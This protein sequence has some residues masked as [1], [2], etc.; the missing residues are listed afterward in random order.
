MFS[1]V[2]A[3]FG[4]SL[5]RP[6]AIAG[7]RLTRLVLVVS[8]EPVLE[9]SFLVAPA[10]SPVEQPV[11]GHRG[12]EAAG[13]RDVGPVD[14]A[15]LLCV[16]AQ[17]GTLRDVAGDVSAAGVRHLLDDRRDLAFQERLQLL[18][19]MEEAE[20]AIEVALARDPADGPAHPLPVCEKRLEWRA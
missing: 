15:V 18:L 12:L 3:V 19:G 9:L 6:V 10:R 20:V 16:R 4:A 2:R 1:P 5:L 8:A 11:V 7:R 13:G 14:G 17:A